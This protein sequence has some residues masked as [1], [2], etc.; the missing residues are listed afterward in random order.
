[1]DTSV[2]LTLLLSEWRRLTGLEGEAIQN[3]DWPRVAVHQARKTEL[4]E[5]IQ[6]ALSSPRASWSAQG[7]AA[8]SFEIEFS[9]TVAELIALEQRNFD[10]LERRRRQRAVDLER[11]ASTLHDLQGVRRAYGSIHQ[12]LWQSYS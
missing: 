8:R 1:M 7:R 4:K 9:S 10:L 6:R 2:D 3:A 5:A 12:A 11:V